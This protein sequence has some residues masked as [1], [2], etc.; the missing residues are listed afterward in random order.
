MNRQRTVLV[1]VTLVPLAL[2]T[3]AR[4]AGR[5]D[6]S[7]RPAPAVLAGAP[8]STV[9]SDDDGG[10]VQIVPRFAPAAAAALSY[11]GGP[12]VAGGDVAAVFLGSAWREATNRGREAGLAE[13]LVSRGTVD[14][15]Q[16]PRFG[17]DD[18]ELVV[19][20]QED[21]LDPL[22]THLVSDL[23]VQRRLNRL[24]SGAT[25]ASEAPAA[26]VVFLAPGL[27]SLLG[28]H[29]ISGR[30]FAAYHNHFHAAG[31]VVVYVVVPYEP[32][33]SRWQSAARLGLFE[34][35]INPEGTGWY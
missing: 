30:D 17:L 20:A 31:G 22:D 25:S 10:R 5:I 6:E 29:L 32:D 7:H 33:A 13:A 16:D 9:A 28:G 11:H 14:P 21:L 23:E 34:A 1:F 18:R 12:V 15:L 19:H 2:A 35:L 4:A 26:F 24:V 27:R 3:F 8:A